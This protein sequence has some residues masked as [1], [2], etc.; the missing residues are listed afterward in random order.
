MGYRN[1]VAAVTLVALPSI[2]V[3][4]VYNPPIG[5]DCRKLSYVIIYYGGAFC[6]CEVGRA[7]M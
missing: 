7:V 2:F 4:A 1:G 3:A 5:L 6:F